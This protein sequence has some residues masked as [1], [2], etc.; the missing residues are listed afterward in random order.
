MSS[1]EDQKSHFSKK[2]ISEEKY[3]IKKETKEERNN[4]KK[5][6][7]PESTHGRVEIEDRKVREKERREDREH[8]I[9]VITEVS[10]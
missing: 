4:E 1:E 2:K 6:G 7:V 5:N 8:M 3:V 10:E 9:K